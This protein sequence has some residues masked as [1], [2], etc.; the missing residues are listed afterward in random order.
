M[1][2]SEVNKIKA[3]DEYTNVEGMELPVG[4]AMEKRLFY[5][6]PIQFA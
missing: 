3:W 2:I 1:E 6:V 5:K 4:C